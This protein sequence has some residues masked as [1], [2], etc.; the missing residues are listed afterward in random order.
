MVQSIWQLQTYQ[1]IRHLDL[2]T[3]SLFSSFGIDT[4]GSRCA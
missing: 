2:A 3:W 4:V 1:I